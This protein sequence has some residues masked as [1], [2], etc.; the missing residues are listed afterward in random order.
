M[1]NH[2]IRFQRPLARLAV[3]AALLALAA[4]AALAGGARTVIV[5]TPPQPVTAPPTGYIPQPVP[6]YPA[7]AGAP[8]PIQPLPPQVTYF[9]PP[10]AVPVIVPNVGG[11]GR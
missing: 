4:P 2:R 11:H 6:S 7:A 10:Q 5:L 9:T 1:T 8:L 3:T